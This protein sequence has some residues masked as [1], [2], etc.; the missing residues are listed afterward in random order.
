[1]RQTSIKGQ[2]DFIVSHIRSLGNYEADIW[3]TEGI[4]HIPGSTSIPIFPSVPH[5]PLLQKA[6]NDRKVAVIGKS[7]NTKQYTGSEPPYMVAYPLIVQDLLLGAIQIIRLDSLPFSREEVDFFDGLT[8]NAAVALQ[9]SHQ[10]IIKNWRLEQL[11]LVRTVS[12]QIANV[13]DLDELCLKVTNL[14]RET[15]HYYAVTIFTVVAG[16]E[17]MTFRGCAGPF[18]TITASHPPL[19]AQFGRGIVGIAA[20]RGEELLANDVSR[21]PIYLYTDQLPHTKA[22]VALPLKVED[23]VLGILDIQ[24]E[25]LF[26]FHEMD[27][28]VLRSLADNIALAV[29]GTRLYS[30]VKKHA[31]QLSVV[32]EVGKALSSIL[33]FDLLLKQIVTLIHE[34]FHYPYI[35]LFLLQKENNQLVYRA[36]AGDR[37]KVIDEIGLQYSLDDPAGMIPWVARSGIT[38]IANDVTQEP[39]YRPSSIYPGETISEMTIPLMFG[40]EALGVLDIQSDQPDTFDESDR[41]LFETLADSI[42]IAI[43]NSILFNSERWRRQAADSLREVAG[44]LSS[45]IALEKLMDIILTELDQ[46]LPC[47]AS[48]IWLIEDEDRTEDDPF[49]L[50]LAAVHGTSMESITK[51]C[52]DEP[53]CLDWLNNALQQPRPTVRTPQD[54]HGPLGK[55]MQFNPEYSSI[56]APML[57]GDK[58]VGMIALAHNSSGRYGLESIQMTSAFASYAAVAIQNT[59]LYASAQEQAWIATVLLQV[60]EATQSITTVDELLKAVVRLTPLLVGVAGCSLFLWEKNLEAFGI[61][62][63]HG[64]EFREEI[65]EKNWIKPDQAPAL[66]R[67]VSDRTPVVL[68]NIEESFPILLRSE[69]DDEC[70]QYALL[71]LLSRGTM[72]GAC[73]ISFCATKRS[74]SGPFME[75]QRLAIIQGIAHQTAIAVENIRL[76]ESQQQETYISAVLLQVAQTVVSFSDLE[77][78]FS[79][80]V[81][82]TQILAGSQTC[83]IYLWNEALEGYRAVQVSGVSG[84]K[85]DELLTSL[86][87]SEQA[88]LLEDIILNDSIVTLPISPACASEPATWLDINPTDQITPDALQAIHTPVLIGV[89]LSVKG[90]SFG[91]MLVVDPGDEKIY[92]NKR[93]EII[94]GIGRQTSLAIQ[95]DRLQH[96]Q[97]TQEKLEREFQ[98]AREIQ[99]TFLPTNYPHPDGWQLDTRWRPA[100][101]VGGDFFDIFSLPNH[102]LALV[103]ADVSDK[104]ISAA[105]YMTL[106][107]TLIRT[108]AQQM[109]TPAKILAQVNDLILRDTPHGMFITALLG[110]LDTRTGELSYANAGHNLPIIRRKASQTLETLEKGS[111]PLGILEKLAFKDSKVILEPGDTLLMYTDGITKSFMETEFFGE[112]RLSQAILLPDLPNATSILES[113]DS[114]LME[115]SGYGQPSDDVTALAIYRK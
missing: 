36:G 90:E 53:S 5:T 38:L 104:G 12:Q 63:S 102:R 100:R 32:S 103:I 39:H 87:P 47:D 16:K 60:A 96:A 114:S 94:T 84:E 111:M 54:P 81:H 112:E 55:A 82:I 20:S 37:A 9:I 108:V 57:I 14:I 95:N 46:I 76:L 24:S 110:I 25:Q 61:A 83:A 21:E 8:S 66:Q 105:L 68:A 62:G 44:L 113:M 3:F 29:E 79:S 15:F 75:D 78:I 49:P 40:R 6:V 77:D 80:I 34:K 26:A 51:S 10:T 22:E 69:G 109:N 52:C 64:M 70:L 101:D 71:P 19:S 115:F 23:R 58:P 88:R 65:T 42:A 99:Q 91:V 48:A 31:E 11:S 56:A 28:R 106:T 74:E 1:M 27:M 45:N 7:G 43:R 97:V 85:E 92:F 73:L 18:E 30:D 107:R 13:L 33:D 50:K 4:S 72:L 89:P 59:R 2:A 35:H 67:L 98:L 17:Q 41:Q 93:L 86:I